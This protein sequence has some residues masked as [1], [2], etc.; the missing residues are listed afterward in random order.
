MLR[1][2][3]L[4]LAGRASSKTKSGVIRGLLYDAPTD[5]YRPEVL[6][7]LV[8]LIGE[9]EVSGGPEGWVEALVAQ[10]LSELCPAAYFATSDANALKLFAWTI[11]R[12]AGAR[13]NFWKKDDFNGPSLSRRFLNRILGAGDEGQRL[14]FLLT[15]IGVYLRDGLNPEAVADRTGPSGMV[16]RVEVFSPFFH[17]LAASRTFHFLAGPVAFGGEDA[18][19]LGIRPLARKLLPVLNA[20]VET[21]HSLDG[22]LN[23]RNPS[24]LTRA[25]KLIATAR[26]IQSVIAGSEYLQERLRLPAVRSRVACG[27]FFIH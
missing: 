22:Y 1:E 25:E 13:T 7:G 3:V 21:L 15:I 17:R 9:L 19:G 20:H 11:E 27:D 12:D 5:R 6:K 8:D 4:P 2:H 23:A 24:T 18:E 14:E 10:D 16:E 26:E